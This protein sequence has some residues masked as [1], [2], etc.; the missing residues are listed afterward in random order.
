M[1]QFVHRRSLFEVFD[2]LRILCDV[3]AVKNGDVCPQL[4]PLPR[5][6]LGGA[7]LWGPRVRV[8]AS[9]QEAI[10]IS[11]FHSAS[12]GSAYF[13]FRT[14]PCSVIRISPEKSPTGCARMAV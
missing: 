4:L 14:S 6:A 3:T 9:R 7:R 10:M 12:T 5:P 1:L 11:R 13:Q 8:S 2:H